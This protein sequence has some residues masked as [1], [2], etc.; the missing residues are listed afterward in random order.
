MSGSSKKRDYT[1]AY[2][3]GSYPLKSGRS[4]Y[5]RSFHFTGPVVPEADIRGSAFILKQ[6]D[7]SPIQAQTDKDTFE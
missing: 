7:T 6:L 4:E 2:S 3:N 5:P 1:L